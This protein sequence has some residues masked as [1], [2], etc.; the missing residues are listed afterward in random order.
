MVSVMVPLASQEKTR[1]AG[2]WF[3]ARAVVRDDAATPTPVERSRHV[4][5]RA[6]I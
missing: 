2:A 3:H 5:G 4:G 6:V 1:A